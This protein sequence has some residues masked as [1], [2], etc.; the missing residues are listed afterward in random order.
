MSIMNYQ[1]K[2]SYN[3]NKKT[4]FVNFDDNTYA[5]V[6][7]VEK[8]ALKQ[9]YHNLIGIYGNYDNTKVVVSMDALGAVEV[10]PISQ[11]KAGEGEIVKHKAFGEVTVI[12]KLD[13]KMTIELADGTR[14]NVVEKFFMNG[15][16]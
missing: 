14:K 6:V 15:I 13:G 7:S 3:G 16:Q 2:T 12:E 8:Q 4:T 10:T 11:E 5:K 9:K 1:I